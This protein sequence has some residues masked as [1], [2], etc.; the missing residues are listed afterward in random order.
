[1][2]RQVVRGD[3]LEH[4]LAH[5]GDGQQVDLLLGGLVQH[6]FHHGEDRVEEG[7]RVQDHNLRMRMRGADRKEKRGGVGRKGVSCYYLACHPTIADAFKD[8]HTHNIHALCVLVPMPENKLTHR[9][10]YHTYAS[11]TTFLEEYFNTKEVNTPTA[12]Y[13]ATESHATRPK[14]NLDYIYGKQ[15]R[16]VHESNVQPH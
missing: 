2:Q 8:T 13:S 7:R 15:Y 9:Y 5:V 14:L 4:L 12:S 11:T 16:G 10:T 6:R 3:N 1:M